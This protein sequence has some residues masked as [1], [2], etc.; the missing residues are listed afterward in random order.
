ME[1]WSGEAVDLAADVLVVG[2]GPA[3]A[4]AAWAAASKGARVVLVDKGY[5][6]ASGAAA[7]SGNSLLNPPPENR[8]AVIRARYQ[9]GQYLGDLR[10]MERIFDST[11]RSLPLVESWGY[12]FPQVNGESARESLWGPEYLKVLRGALKAAGVRILDQSPAQELLVDGDGVVAGARGIQRQEGRAWTVRSKATVL[13]AGGAAF[14]SKVL[15]CNTNTGDALL[16]AARREGFA[17]QQLLAA[18][19]VVRREKGDG[20]Y[21]RFRNRLI[22]P[23][24][25]VANNVIAFGGRALAANERAKYLNSPES[26]LYDKSNQLYAL[27]WAREAIGEGGQ[28]VVVEGYMDALIPHQAGV[29]NVVANLGTALT[30]RQVRLLSRYA[31]EVVLI[32]DADTAGQLA[33]ERSLEMFLAQQLHVRVA[34]IPEGKDPCDY[35]LAAGGEAMRALIAS[36][37]DA[38]EYAWGRR[39]AQLEQAGGNLAQRR[40]IVEEFLRLV[41]SCSTFGAIDEVRRGQLAQHIAHLLNISSSEVQQQMR[42][43]ARAIPRANLPQDAGRMPAAHEGGT[44][45]SHSRADLTER[46]VLEVLLNRP[47]LFDSVMEKLDATDFEDRDFALIAQEIWRRGQEGHLASEELVASETMAPLGGLLAELIATG[48]RM[49]NHEQTLA[50]AVEHI[51]YRRNRQQMQGLKSAGYTDEMLRLTEQHL[52]KPDAR[53]RPRIT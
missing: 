5:M 1:A 27:N 12:R 31:K 41:V 21:D 44:P 43:M 38:L 48:Q 45:S 25:D 6:G 11:W 36:A 52:K 15:G 37:P 35:T 13:A 28:A 16:M 10:W 49:G 39:A 34:T 19:L 42:R 22:F 8:E 23:I 32:Y 20:C 3:A 51:L 50:G 40:E 7:A 29:G 47:D 53:R 26:V 30:D 2:G 9:S 46:Q 33:A 4:W 17:E 14:L 24:L 18:G